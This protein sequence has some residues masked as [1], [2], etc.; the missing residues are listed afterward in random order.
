M[1]LQSS[2]TNFELTHIPSTYV[3]LW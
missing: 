1:A 2:A 3:L